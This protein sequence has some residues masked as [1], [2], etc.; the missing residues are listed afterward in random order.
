[1]LVTL[2]LMA[3]TSI[4]SCLVYSLLRLLENRFLKVFSDVSIASIGIIF[5]WSM[6]VGDAEFALSILAIC[7]AVGVVG[8]LFHLKSGGKSNSKFASC[9]FMMTVVVGVIFIEWLIFVFFSAAGLFL[10]TV[11]S[12]ISKHQYLSFI[13]FATQILAPPF[14]FWIIKTS[15]LRPGIDKHLDDREGFY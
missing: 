2:G 12:A 7:L 13:L 14:L 15:F 4:V 6:T 1:M 11:E 3:I 10:Q 9:S 5:L 8:G